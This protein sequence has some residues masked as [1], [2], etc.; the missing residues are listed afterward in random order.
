MA[1]EFDDYLTDDVTESWK[2]CYPVWKEAGRVNDKPHGVRYVRYTPSF[3]KRLGQE[4]A[5]RFRNDWKYLVTKLSSDDPIVRVCAFDLLEEVTWDFECNC[6]RVPEVLGRIE[7][8]IP[9]P[10]LSDIRSEHFFKDFT[11]TTVGEFLPFMIEH[12]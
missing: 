9:E 4:F 1:T 2:R 8:E 7:I 6:D 3:G 5:S 11:G 10:A 12:G